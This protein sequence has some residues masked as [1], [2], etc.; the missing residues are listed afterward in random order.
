[1]NKVVALPAPEPRSIVARNLA[2]V[3]AGILVV[4]VV[5]Q[6]FAFEKFIPLM[7]DYWL[8]GGRGSA[9]LLAGLLVYAEIFAL[10]FLLRMQL[11]PL[12]RWF[13]TVCSVFVP[14]TWL[15]LAINCLLRHDSLANG[16]MLGAKVA[17][18]T[19]LQFALAA[20]LT[21]LA[22]YIAY[23]LQPKHKK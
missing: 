6:L 13:S 12:M 16:G 10:P 8:P 11:S 4:L 17:V 23:G 7:S 5:A 20:I 18:S 22:L 19:E 14:L 2:W 1:M 3:Y 9:T 15:I 21:V